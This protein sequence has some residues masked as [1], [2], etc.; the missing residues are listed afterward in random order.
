MKYGYLDCFPRELKFKTSTVFQGKAVS[1]MREC[2]KQEIGEGTRKMQHVMKLP[3]TGDIDVGTTSLMQLRR[4]GDK[5]TNIKT[6]LETSS[7]Y[8]RSMEDSNSVDDKS[9]RLMESKK[10]STRVRRGSLKLMEVD[11]AM[12]SD[13][14]FKQWL[15]TRVTPFAN[16]PVE[17]LVEEDR[18]ETMNRMRRKIMESLN[19]EDN[20]Q[21]HREK[22]EIFEELSEAH[23][24]RVMQRRRSRNRRSTGLSSV[25]YW[26]LP[27]GSSRIPWNISIAEIEMALKKWS[28]SI[29]L[30]FRRIPAG[31]SAWE[32]DV[33]FMFWISMFIF[34]YIEDLIRSLITL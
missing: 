24:R 28:R 11:D 6:Q 17:N 23:K 29:P 15:N 1:S 4:C 7:T 13:H 8:Y 19:E 31:S 20:R 5:D 16:P 32:N 25:I 9:E 2:S 12:A 18:T 21:A 10:S 30:L 27:A 34:N 14:E 3:Q 22:R 26:S 33:E